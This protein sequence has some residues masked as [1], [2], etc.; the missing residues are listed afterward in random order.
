MRKFA[1]IILIL[2]A[3]CGLH[4]MSF[5][6][7]LAMDH[8]VLVGNLWCFPLQTDSLTYLY[9]PNTAKLA[10]DENQIPQFSFLRYVTAPQN[11]QEGTNTIQEAAGGGIL[12]FLVL[13]D[14]NKDSVTEAQKRL[15]K[16]LKNEQVKIRGPLIF[17][18]GQFVLTSSIL[19]PVSG[20]EEQKLLAVGQAPV[21][22]GNKV[23]L[24][25]ELDP[26]RSKLLLES[27]KL[28][29][30][31]VS[32]TFDLVFSG[33]SDNYKAK[34]EID[35][36]QVKQHQGFSAGGTVY[37][38]SADIEATFDELIRNNAIKLTTVGNDAAME[39]L[40]NTVYNKL[41]DLMFAPVE[42]TT[43]EKQ[44]GG[45][46]MDVI[47]GITGKNSALSSR[48][49][50]GFG[51]HL[52]YKLKKMNS[53]GKSV[54]LFDGRSTV[55]RHHLIT[56]NAGKLYTK[57]GNDP[58][59]FKDVPLWDPT[60]QQREVFV[61]V[62]GDLEPEFD[63]LLNSVTVTLNKEH[64]S[65][66]ETVKE[67]ILKRKSLTDS[68]GPLSMT[69]GS[70]KDDDRQR[71]LEYKYK[72]HWQ[73]QGGGAYHSD[74]I[75]ETASMI[76]LY[77]PFKRHRIEIEGDMDLLIANRI[78][79][80]IVGINYTF[81]NRQKSKKLTIKPNKPGA[82]AKFDITLPLNQQEVDYTITWIKE[83]GSQSEFKGKDKHGL[84]FIDELLKEELVG[85]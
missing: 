67:L 32:L 66:R 17:D 81:F 69:Y 70:D 11:N 3:C 85:E 58:L 33:I 78:R 9:L 18:Q 31:D 34:L 27:F 76:N 10:Y 74:W 44:D 45:G 62:D 77:T 38:V 8:G 14:T 84:I 40:L 19:N 41:L 5:S 4:T 79:A 52:G 15:R 72:A 68:Q 59:I 24:T 54:L 21:Q 37:Y 75:N 80:V 26:V 2:S 71:W 28:S 83:D 1:N 49:L 7:Q 30:S 12:H 50:T 53:K 51:A 60:F 55:K 61:G 35:W 63:H 22:Q 47:K 13:Y 82:D 16:L 23:A 48:K 6:Q 56:F 36:S 42:P 65:G 39:G 25:F 20:S 64:Q 73:F 46:F 57:Y 29:T 43:T